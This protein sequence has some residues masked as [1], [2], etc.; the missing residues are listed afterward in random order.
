MS[1]PFQA[2][3]T[4]FAAMEV[5]GLGRPGSKTGVLGALSRKKPAKKN[6]DR[7]VTAESENHKKRS[8]G[9]EQHPYLSDVQ[10]LLQPTTLTAYR[11]GLKKIRRNL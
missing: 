10:Q 1:E 4:G 7:D 2:M 5:L 9:H 8:Y 3:E 11:F 6:H